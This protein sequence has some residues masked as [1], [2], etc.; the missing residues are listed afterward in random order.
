MG[1]DDKE[2]NDGDNGYRKTDNDGLKGGTGNS[3]GT[4]MARGDEFIGTWGFTTRFPVMI[5]CSVSFQT[6]IVNHIC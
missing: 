4:V 3:R 6:S 5:T 1:A 2:R